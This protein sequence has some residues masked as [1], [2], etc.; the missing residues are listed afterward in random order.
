MIHSRWSI[1]RNVLELAKNKWTVWMYNEEFSFCE[2]VKQLDRFICVWRR[3]T[4]NE[5]ENR[6]VA[7]W[8]LFARE[9]EYNDEKRA[10]LWCAIETYNQPF[11]H[12]T[13]TPD[14]WSHR[15][16][17]RAL[18]RR[19]YRFDALLVFKFVS[20]IDVH[21]RLCMRVVAPLLL[22]SPLFSI[23]SNLRREN[24]R[25]M[26]ERELTEWNGYIYKAENLLFVV[27]YRRIIQRCDVVLFI[28][29]YE[30]EL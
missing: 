28:M 13:Y 9:E 8:A 5:R 11:I 16:Y 15:I 23:L 7:R 3:A 25:E 14:L 19:Y 1:N 12:V 30:D 17:R 18:F 6:G 4:C 10:A 27:S 2:D 24:E 20:T 29:I 22:F 26:R 21:E